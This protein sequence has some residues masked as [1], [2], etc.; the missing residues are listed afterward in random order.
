[1]FSLGTVLVESR[2]QKGGTM[3]VTAKA[4]KRSVNRR[5]LI[6]G[7]LLAGGAATLGAG[8][9][10]KGEPAYAQGSGVRLS[11]G[12]IAILRFLAAAELL[13]SDLWTQ[14]AELGGIGDLQPVE[15]TPNESLNPYQTA[16]S[17][18]TL[19]ARNT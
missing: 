4:T 2:S 10:G 13:E 9:L 18:L 12:D 1:M 15:V 19:T 17:N 6:K 14:Y 16:L 5:A 7:G 11:R 3:E 8:L